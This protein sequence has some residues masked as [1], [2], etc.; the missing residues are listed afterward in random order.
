MI[1]IALSIGLHHTTRIMLLFYWTYIIELLF[2]KNEQKK[3]YLKSF[4]CGL[5][6]CWESI[7]ITERQ[8]TKITS[9]FVG[10]KKKIIYSNEVDI[11]KFK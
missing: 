7:K 9:K 2:K 6:L 1:N 8:V 10:W 5:K 3:Q 4:L 11:I